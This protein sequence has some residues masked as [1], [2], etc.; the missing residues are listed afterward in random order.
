[1]QVPWLQEDTACFQ[2]VRATHAF[3]HGPWYDSV[4]VEGDGRAIWYAKLLLLFWWGGEQ[5]AYVQWYQVDGRRGLEGRDV[6]V[7]EGCKR[8]KL[9]NDFSVISLLSIKERIRVIPDLAQYMQDPNLYRTHPERFWQYISPFG[10]DRLP[11]DNRQIELDEDGC[12]A[13]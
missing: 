1:M 12:E 13:S 2:P 8:V 11:P 9:C 6:L 10:W 3:T 7:K 5:C 4:A